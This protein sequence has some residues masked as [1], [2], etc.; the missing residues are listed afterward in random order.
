[1]ELLCI[2][3]LFSTRIFY[4]DAPGFASDCPCGL[5]YPWLIACILYVSPHLEIY[6]FKR[7]W[8]SKFF[9]VIFYYVYI[10][11]HIYPMLRA[12]SRFWLVNNRDIWSRISR[13]TSSWDIKTK[14][15]HWWR[16]NGDSD[17]RLRSLP[18]RYDLVTLCLLVTIIAT[19]RW[20]SCGPGTGLQAHPLK[21][22]YIFASSQEISIYDRILPWITRKLRI[23]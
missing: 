9:L 19:L 18:L 4:R 5:Q 17:R 6:F 22:Q 16:H 14:E 21:S 8:A 12:D 15:R 7:Q 1:M 23:W 13:L 11:I 20:A 10:D 3:R 2:K